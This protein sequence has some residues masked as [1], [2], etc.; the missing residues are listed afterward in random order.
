VQ[1]HPFR[2]WLRE[3]RVPLLFALLILIMVPMR[4]LWSPDEPD[5]AQCVRE[6]RER[7]SWLLP[8]LNG[9]PYSEK[10]ILFYWLMKGS[11]ITLDTLTRGHGFVH[12]VAAYA[13]RLPSALAA[14]GFSFGFRRWASRFLQADLADLASMI[15]ATTPIWLWQSQAIQIDLVFAALLAW[16]WLAWLGGY[17]LVRD[18]AR[19]IRV[20]EE[21]TWFLQAYVALALAFLAKGPL[22]LVLSVAL[23][24]TFLA[25]QRDL[26]ALRRSGLGWGLGLMALILLPWYVAAGLK[27]GSAYA[28]QLLVH[29]NLERA[30][31]AWDHLQPPWRYVEYLASD[32]FPWTLLLPALALFLARSGALR[33][34]AARFLLLAVGVPFVLLSLVQSKQGK[35]LLMVYPF[36]ALLLASMLQPVAVEAVGSTRIRRL[37]ALLAL[38]LGLPGAAL[39]AV[40]VLGLGGAELQAQLQP[41]RGPLRLACAFFLLGALSVAGRA[42]AR[43]G[44]FLVRETALS[45]GLVFLVIGTWGFRL[46]DGQKSFRT[47]TAQVEPLIA[48]RQVYFWQTIRSGAMVYTGQVMPEVRSREEL[49]ARLGPEDRLVAMRRDW[50]QDHWG[51]EPQARERFEVILQVPVGADDVLLLRRLPSP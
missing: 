49:E 20:G 27:G 37:G 1:E 32:F 11:A 2:V 51:M 13:L 33:S 6:M 17:L 8:Y 18:H 10:P 15:L 5:F 40:S 21:R 42:W 31:R 47:W 19:P 12:G 16:S 38:G 44:R 24:A 26:K 28:F 3:N 34:T 4:D 7:G 36:L 35:Y 14:I 25:W 30:V 39:L 50:E 48:H 23:L 41:Y 43:E 45:L 9:Q 29:Q 22:A 46:L